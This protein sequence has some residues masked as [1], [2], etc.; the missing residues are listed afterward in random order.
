LFVIRVD[1]AHP[2]TVLA[3]SD[4]RQDCHGR[5]PWP[6]FAIDNCYRNHEFESNIGMSVKAQVR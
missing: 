5:F 2:S 4:S 1:R 6:A 3:Q